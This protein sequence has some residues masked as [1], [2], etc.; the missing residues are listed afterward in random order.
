MNISSPTSLNEDGLP[1]G[2]GEVIRLALRHGWGNIIVRI[3]NASKGLGQTLIKYGI[4]H[5][6]SLGI[7]PDLAISH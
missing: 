6:N 3:T 1:V 5:A 7:T 4:N 2:V